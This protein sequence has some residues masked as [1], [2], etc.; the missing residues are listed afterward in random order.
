MTTKPRPAPHRRGSLTP[1]PSAPSTTPTSARSTA[2]HNYTQPGGFGVDHVPVGHSETGS[3]IFACRVRCAEKYESLQA[4][5]DAFP[6]ARLL[7]DLG[8]A[9]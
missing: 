3:E 2:A 4:R 9:R 6:G 8:V 1:R 5:R 7:R